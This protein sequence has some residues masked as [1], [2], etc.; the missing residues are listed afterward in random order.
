MTVI[1]WYCI[2]FVTQL[3]IDSEAVPCLGF[4]SSFTMN[5]GVCV[6]FHIR[7]WSG[8]VPRRGIAGSD[9]DSI[10]SFWG[11]SILFST[12]AA[13]IYIPTNSVAGLPF[14]YSLQDL[15]FADFLNMVILTGMRWYFYI[16]LSCFSLI[17][18]N[19]EHLFMCL[20][21]ISLSSLEKCL[22]RS[23]ANFFFFI[24][25]ELHYLFVYLEIKPLSVGSFANIFSKVLSSFKF[26]FKICI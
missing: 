4:V 22:F 20:L 9:G 21:T 2:F 23:V 1:P 16:V 19:V 14:Q 10:F 25:I 26:V 11:T 6:S 12:P 15:L 18:S 3:L 17:V 24:Y 13:L 7:D 8:Y 5:T